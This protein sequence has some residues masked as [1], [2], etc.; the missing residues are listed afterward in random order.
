MKRL[1]HLCRERNRHLSALNNCDFCVL[2][3][4][5]DFDCMLNQTNIGHNN[6]K[7]YVIQV[8]QQGAQFYAWNR[9][10]RVVSSLEYRVPTSTG[11]SGEELLHKIQSHRL[12]AIRNL[13]GENTSYG[14]NSHPVIPGLRRR[15]C[16]D[17]GKPFQ[18]QTPEEIFQAWKNRRMTQELE[19]GC[20]T[21]SP[22]NKAT[23]P[24]QPRSL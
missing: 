23:K 15:R 7:Y 14:G 11:V 9:W 6:N 16:F 8:L 3:L 22:A 10:G 12:P 5:D 19:R 2:Q 20:R 24:K 17:P 13:Q 18:A 21:N 4:V 1:C